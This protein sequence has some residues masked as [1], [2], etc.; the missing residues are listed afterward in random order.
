MATG[1]K[2]DVSDYDFEIFIEKDGVRTKRVDTMQVRMVLP[3]YLCNPNLTPEPGKPDGKFDL[4]K[5]GK[6]S[7]MIEHAESGYV[8]LDNSDYEVLK[9]RM[10]VLCRF[11]GK[12]FYEIVER[13][14]EA[15]TVELEEKK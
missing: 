1:K 6:V 7:R 5:I 13:I 9:T 12:P 8:V 15:P 10:G 14:M 11:L 3:D 2:I 4:Y